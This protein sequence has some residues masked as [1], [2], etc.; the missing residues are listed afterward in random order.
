MRLM[1]TSAALHVAAALAFLLVSASARASM[2]SWDV[3][4][5]QSYIR[6]NL[7]DQAVTVDTT[8]ATIRLRDANS[9]SNWT[10][11][12]GKRAFLDGTIATD[13]VDG[14]SIE[15]LSGLNNLFAL[16]QTSLR[17]NPAAFNPNLVDGSNPD[18]TYTDTSTALA[19]FGARVRG[20]VSILTLDLGYL[21]IRD[22]LFDIGSGIVPLDGLGNYLGNTT[23]VG[24]P[25]SVVDVDGLNAALV[26][27]VIPDVYHASLTVPSQTNTAGGTVTNLGGLLR[28][29]TVSVNVP[30]A[31]DLDG[32]IVTGS[33]TGQIVAFAVVPEPSSLL[34]AGIAAL[35]LCWAGRGRFSTR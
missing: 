35:G 20:S 9:T 28:Q 1:K 24:I 31:I 5:S 27:Q 12:G 18:G 29:L 17:P 8:T 6:L 21:A 4:P 10:D 15:F 2:I 14:A 23:A 32:T 25:S 7:P 30:I 11:A 33:A 13:F 16:E 26:G 3:D 19:A 34:M 22:V